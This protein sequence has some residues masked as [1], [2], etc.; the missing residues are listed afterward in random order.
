MRQWARFAHTG[1]L[2]GWP[3]QALAAVACAGGVVLA[4]TGLA[5]ASRRVIAWPGWTRMRS[6]APHPIAVSGGPTLQE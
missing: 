4:V 5:L 3:G 1:E 2:G 6:N